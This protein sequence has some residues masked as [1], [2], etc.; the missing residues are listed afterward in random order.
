M[1]HE[2]PTHF[3]PPI[4]RRGLGGGG[5]SS[6]SIALEAWR[7]KLDVEFT[8]DNLQFFNITDGSRSVKFDFAFPESVTPKHVRRSLDDKSGTN[9]LLRNGGIRVP[10]GIVIDPRNAS[11]QSLQANAEKIGY[12]LVLKPNVGSTGKG[13][14]TG[15][16]SWSE[17]RE[18]FEYLVETLKPRLILME[19]HLEGEDYR[20]LVIGDKAVSVV[21]RI[22][23][24]VVGDGQ[25]S[26]EQLIAIKNASRKHNPFLASG[27]I[28][29]DYEVEKELAVRDLSL[30]SVPTVG[31]VV[32]LRRVANA[33]AGGDVAD[34]T[35][36]FPEHIKSAAVR[37]ARTFDGIVIAG[38]DV[39]YKA[40][41]PATPQNYAVL[42]INPRP[43]I[44]VNMYP[45]SGKGRDPAGHLIDLM[46]PGTRRPDSLLAETIRFNDSVIKVAIRSGS[47]STVQLKRIPEH[48]CG[49]RWH[50]EF[51]GWGER[52]PGRRFPRVTLQQL[53]TTMDISGHCDLT[54][55]GNVH[56]RFAAPN[57]EVANL[58]LRRA[59][60]LLRLDPNEIHAW[61]QPVT[62]GFTV[63]A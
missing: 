1:S 29:I 50:T 4:I 24:N 27:L 17:L 46:F 11:M 56:I 57:R 22:P 49:E 34:V 12:P 61:T 59:G 62:L 13:V 19:E 26:I 38:V 15:L 39:I 20:V 41:F 40:G 16:A 7:R 52:F 60:D 42:E 58:F 2:W 25:A 28:K 45:T 6:Y 8:S 14:L 9:M 23:A 36:E 30:E 33:S 44:G 31:R 5:V 51:M 63:S 55:N 18:G 53:A 3:A 21:H 48:L 35:D 10:T 54:K 47:V 32:P 37:A 43:H